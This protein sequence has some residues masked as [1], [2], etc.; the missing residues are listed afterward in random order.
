MSGAAGSNWKSPSAAHMQKHGLVPLPPEF[1]PTT[2]EQLLLDMYETVK[3]YERQAA[4]LKEE[5]ARKKLAARD[6]E[7]QQ[8]LA[9]NKNKKRRRKKT[10]AEA[11]AATGD[12]SE[13]DLGSDEDLSN[14][15]NDEDNED[16]DDPNTLHERRE[17]KLAALREEVEE[18]KQPKE[19]EADALRAQFLATSAE[20]A[21]DN[22]G[23]SLKRKKMEAKE[24]K[25]LI[26]N[27]SAGATPP[28]EFS[29]KL[30][31]KRGKVL[32]P[33]TPDQGRWT[34]PEGVM[35]PNDGAF[36]VEMED[37]DMAKA[38]D[39]SGNNT[40]AIKFMAPSDS[41]RFSINI[42]QPGNDS[43]NSVLFHFNPR[44]HERGGQLVVNDKQE[45]IWGQAI[46]I[47]LS[48]VPL[49][50]GQTACTLVIQI[51]GDGFD[52]F[53][54]NKH[55]ARWEHRKE[56][57]VGSSPLILQF[58]ST[59]DYGSPEN[60]AVYKVWWGNKEIMA[61]GD[62]SGVAGVN[63]YKAL[64]PRKLFISGLSKIYSEAEVDVRRAELERA[65]RKYGGDRG[66]EAIVPTNT[67]YAFVEMESERQ[68]DLA[69]TDMAGQYR[70]NRARRS[71]HE[72]LQEER[73]AAE[74]AKQGKVKT[75]ADWD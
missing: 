73:A 53:L 59:D 19:S 4:R 71:R 7:F 3:T 17:A 54:D 28:H 24:P 11:A 49:L 70:M 10:A 34:P 38:Q 5:A 56:L 48:Q 32:Y 66:V 12:D 2:E 25:S 55:C 8:K 23:P 57:P 64:H 67:T 63:I 47:P 74:A 69:L 40:L 45:G 20:D 21:I 43:F 18:A 61:K 42:A 65:F 29:E 33:I 41:K 51:N 75:T 14:D 26:A 37:F 27:L 60:W 39:G 15:E 44:H 68:A 62:L 72:A 1:E 35:T 22:V 31:I 58:P 6:A 30:E 46:A 13:S 9:P 36:E 50:F 16:E 52:V